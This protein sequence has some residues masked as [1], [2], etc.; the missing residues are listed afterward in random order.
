VNKLNNKTFLILGGTGSFGKAM[1]MRLLKLN[2]KKIIV[3]SRDELKQYEMRNEIKSKKLEYHIGD[4]RDKSSLSFS[5]KNVDYIFY[6][7]ALKQVPSCEFFPDEAVKTSF[8]GALNVIEL[9]DLFKI[10]KIIFLS[11]DKAVEPI[12]SMGTSK[13]LMEKLVCSK[14]L[15]S[16]T[17]LIITRYGNV[18]ASRGSVLPYFINSIQAKNEV[19]VT[20]KHMTRFLMQIDDALDLVMHALINGRS[21]SIYVRKCFASYISE[22]A[23][24]VGFILNK[25]IHINYT[26]IRVG[27]KIDET[28]ISKYEMSRAKNYKNY[29][30]IIPEIKF[31]Y[32]NFM[33]SGISDKLLNDYNSSQNLLDFK[34]LTKFIQPTV[35]KIVKS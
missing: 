1:V 17:Q 25:K 29:F 32:D 9:A 22:L 5:M 26:G 28:L 23:K 33:T 35:L 10:K 34:K 11:T 21:G 20:S 27:E 19:N 14:S 8:F 18:L 24:S 30:E 6:A 3:F 7:A 2:I 4:V 15:N 13:S 16:N 31:T 12:N